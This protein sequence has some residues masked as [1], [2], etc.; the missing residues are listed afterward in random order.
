MALLHVFIVGL[1]GAGVSK[2][3]PFRCSDLPVGKKNEQTN[4]NV[5]PIEA[6]TVGLKDLHKS[7]TPPESDL[8]V[9]D[10]QNS[11]SVSSQARIYLSYLL[12]F[13]FQS[14]VSFFRYFIVFWGVFASFASQHCK[15]LRCF[16]CYRIPSLLGAADDCW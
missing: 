10:P 1:L 16:C 4:A 6:P 12:M 11:D 3:H 14:V 15:A 7:S 9:I 5:E 13:S 2:K 8:F